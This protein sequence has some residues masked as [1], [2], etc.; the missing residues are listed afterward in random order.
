MAHSGHGN[1]RLSSCSVSVCSEIQVYCLI[2]EVT[3]TMIFK[4]LV[5]VNQLLDKAR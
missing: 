3:T 2:S 5:R 4:L 1:P